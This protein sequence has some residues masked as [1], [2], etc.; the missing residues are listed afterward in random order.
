MLISFEKRERV[1]DFFLNQRTLLSVYSLLAITASIQLFLA[2]THTSGEGY[3]Y[4]DYN[5]Y[6]IFRQSYFH[7]LC[8]KNIYMLFPAEQW[9]LYKYSPTFALA[10]G[11]L[12]HLPDLVGL[13]IWNLFNALVLF[14]AIRMLP[15]AKSQLSLLLWFILIEL[16]TSM[17]NSQSNGLM[18]G[19]LIAAFTCLE[20]KKVGIA[21]LW[22]VVASFIKVYGAIGFCLFLF[23]PDKVR[24]MLY[25]V[26][27]ILLF[28]AVPLLVTP[29]HI[30]LW[31]YHNWI[32]MMAEDQSISYGLSVM[33]WLHTWF[34]ASSGKSIVN[35]TGIV[36]FLLP[37][38][39]FRLY[40]D[41]SYKLLM[42]ALML[43]WVIIFNHKAESPTYIIAVAG[44]G[45]WY[46]S[47]QALV[48]RKV[49]MAFVFVF[50][51]LS[52][53]DIFPEV[54]RHYFEAHTVKALP[55]IVVWT[56]IWVEIMRMKT[57]S[58]NQ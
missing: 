33:G 38:G 3:V 50:T 26:L 51:C 17:Q 25:S 19:L 1:H 7:L 34:G 39:R 37:F 4:T 32:V 8:R 58:I 49:L 54:I 27:W 14:S 20:R 6:V 29:F 24:S 12:A 48:W 22:V 10:M 15:I 47:E 46:F 16:L 21:V 45:I 56:V 5:N 11:L 13:S 42:L 53:S 2:G 23:Y 41:Y 30:L 18:A 35:I 44:V 52:P 31:Q 43:I 9:D 55:C 28:A 36:L 40:Q 57:P